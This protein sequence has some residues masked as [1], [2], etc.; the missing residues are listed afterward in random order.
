MLLT[1]EYEYVLLFFGFAFLIFKIAFAGTEKAPPVPMNNGVKFGICPNFYTYVEDLNLAPSA[2]TK[3][4]FF[5]YCTRLLLLYK[6]KLWEM[7]SKTVRSL[8]NGKNNL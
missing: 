4:R 2:E 1:I 8:Q 6:G 7:T 3:L 5:I